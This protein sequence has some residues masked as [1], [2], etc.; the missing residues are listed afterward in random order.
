MRTEDETAVNSD[1]T[2]D[3]SLVLFQC[4]P[5]LKRSAYSIF[6]PWN[7][8][9]FESSKFGVFKLI[10]IHPRPLF[11][12]ITVPD[13]TCKYIVNRYEV[14]QNTANIY[15]HPLINSFR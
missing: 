10:R 9:R 8:E 6:Q 14:D 3:S 5:Y 13:I 4:E 2:C 12:I 1:K 15:A 11:E 7:K